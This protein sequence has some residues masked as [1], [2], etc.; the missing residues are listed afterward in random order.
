MIGSVPS[1]PGRIRDLRGGGGRGGAGRRPGGGRAGRHRA[2]AVAGPGGATWGRSGGRVGPGGA[3]RPSRDPAQESP[4]AQPAHSPAPRRETG[5]GA[6][7]GRPHVPATCVVVT[8]IDCAAGANAQPGRHLGILATG[9]RVR[10]TGGRVRATSGGDSGHEQPGPGPAAGSAPRA[11]QRARPRSFPCRRVGTP[12]AAGAKG[13]RDG[14]VLVRP[15]PEPEMRAAI[16]A[17]TGAEMSRG[18]CVET[19]AGPSGRMGP[20]GVQAS[21][22]RLPAA[23]RMAPSC[24]RYGPAF[25]TA[26][27]P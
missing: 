20:A 12:C 10:A 27:Q 11:G 25:A 18:M 16:H 3:G 26:T 5:T 15:G 23:R 22:A 9:G 21:L 17:E 6:S 8:A 2:G 24:G 13:A 14:F 19:T 4:N 7:V 1:A